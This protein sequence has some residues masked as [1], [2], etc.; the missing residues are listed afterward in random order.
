LALFVFGCAQ[1]NKVG[2]Y[3]TGKDD[4]DTINSLTAVNPS[5]SSFGGTAYP[6]QIYGFD[7]NED[8][9][10]WY[11]QGFQNFVSTVANKSACLGITGAGLTMTPT[12]CVAYNAGYRST[13][14]GSITFTNAKTTWVAMDENTSGS[15]AGLPNFSRVGST[16]Y[17][18]DDVDA[19]QPAMAFDSQLLMKV[20]TSGGSIT[21]VSDYRK[22]NAVAGTGVNTPVGADPTGGTDAGPSINACIKTGGNGGTC[23]IPPGTYLITTPILQTAYNGTTLDCLSGAY[24]WGF[25]EPVVLIGN[26][27]AEPVIDQTGSVGAQVIGCNIDS[28]SAGSPS[29]IGILQA[30][31][32]SADGFQ[33]AEGEHLEDV[34]INLHTVGSGINGGFGAI[35]VYNYASEEDSYQ[36]LTVQ[37]ETPFVHS[38]ENTLAIQSA[39]PSTPV[40]TPTNCASTCG[41]GACSATGLTFSGANQLVSVNSLGPRML[42]DGGVGTDD[43]GDTYMASNGTPASASAAAFQVGIS[44]ASI[45]GDMQGSQWHGNNEDQ[46]VSGAIPVLVELEPGANFVRNRF[47]NIINVVGNQSVIQFDVPSTG[48][49]SCPSITSSTVETTTNMTAGTNYF[50]ETS[51]NTCT[52]REVVAATFDINNGSSGNPVMTLADSSLADSFFVNGEMLYANITLPSGSQYCVTNS[53][54]SSSF[55][56]PFSCN[57]INIDTSLS[58]TSSIFNIGQA[59]NGNGVMAQWRATDSLPTG[60]YTAGLNHAGN[61]YEYIIQTNGNGQFE[62]L[63]GNSGASISGGGSLGANSSS[64]FGTM[65][66][67]ATTANVLTTGQTCP[68]N[69][70]AIFQDNTTPGGI[71]VTASNATT[72]TFSATSSDVGSYIAGCN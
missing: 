41:G 27:G 11:E 49:P 31:T 67:L 56:P 47:T 59:A 8:A 22:S 29:E 57:A 2:P 19:S 34:S 45:A 55:G 35:G 18:I 44:G 17:L 63:S 20:T 6:G 24:A 21:A 42:I 66:G 37:A 39:N 54:G 43:Y 60:Y 72:I 51:N 68:H 15:N 23:L 38:A 4:S 46:Q 52:G 70:V 36:N 32:P 3:H 30:R 13:E 25:T 58:N 14:T 61:A 26:T 5:L 33:Y 53:Y 28:T 65:T 69:V 16:H 50:K 62:S 64:V 40:C 48:S 7:A 12:A 10:R 9:N 1:V 71:K